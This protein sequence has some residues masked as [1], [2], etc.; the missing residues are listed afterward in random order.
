MVIV[1]LFQ[2]TGGLAWRRVRDVAPY[3][4]RNDSILKVYK[5]LFFFILYNRKKTLF[6]TQ[7]CDTIYGEKVGFFLS[8]NRGNNPKFGY[9]LNF[10]SPGGAC[11]EHRAEDGNFHR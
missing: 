11:R 7:N 8:K 10:Q 1:T 9:A 6:F 5:I 4:P 3:G 2:S